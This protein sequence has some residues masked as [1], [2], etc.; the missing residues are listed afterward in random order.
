M[1]KDHEDLLYTISLLQTLSE[2]KMD[3]MEYMDE[4]RQSKHKGY[5]FNRVQNKLDNLELLTSDLLKSL[6]E[7][8]RTIQ[9]Q[10]FKEARKWKTKS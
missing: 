1:K 8:T 9:K 6:D 3:Y 5:D 10:S 4:L 7:D 2:V